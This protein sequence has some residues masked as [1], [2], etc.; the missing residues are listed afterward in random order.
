MSTSSDPDDPNRLPRHTTPTWEIELLSS[1]ALVYALL[2]MPGLLD[3]AM[4]GL[5]PHASAT[6]QSSI[7][8]ITLYLQAGVLALCAAFVL[9]LVL[10]AWWVALVGVHSVF[11]QG[12][13]WERLRFGPLSNE[14]LRRLYRPLPQRI[15]QMDNAA[16]VVFASGLGV[17]LMM[18]GLAV[19]AGVLVLVCSALG[20]WQVLGLSQ[21]Q[22]L[23]ILGL[24][25]LMPPQLAFMVDLWLRRRPPAPGTLLHR[26]LTRLIAMQGMFPGINSATL[27]INTVLSNLLRRGVVAVGVLVMMVA[28]MVAGLSLP[29]LSAT[30]VPRLVAP[31]E[32]GPLVAQS[33]NYRDQRKGLDRLLP[34]PTLASQELGEAPLRLFLPMRRDRHPEVLRT[35][36]P[37]LQSAD[38]GADAHTAVLLDCLHRWADPRLDGQPLPEHVRIFSKDPQSGLEGVLWR[39]P[40]A[41][42][43]PGRHVI[44]LHVRDADV[45][46]TGGRPAQVLQIVFF[47]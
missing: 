10:R 32:A 13:R 34:G 30:L 31:A 43:A 3:R 35:R 19:G 39:V 12:P 9:H 23:L 4:L 1:G 46:S 2:Q 20:H 24:V 41:A 22:W 33:V 28:I 18:L 11:P 21:V 6:F 8:M 16:S 29:M 45:D 27:M 40:N 7:L 42:I 44:S 38:T 25:V 37:E 5:L 36:C 26:V 15:E 17:G 14:R 47:K